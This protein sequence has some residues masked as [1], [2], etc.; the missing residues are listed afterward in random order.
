M[1]GTVDLDVGCYCYLRF[2]PMNRRGSLRSSTEEDLKLEEPGKRASVGI[3][4]LDPLAGM[5]SFGPKGG[6]GGRNGA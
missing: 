6:Q 2:V 4:G 1:D 5:E 3:Y